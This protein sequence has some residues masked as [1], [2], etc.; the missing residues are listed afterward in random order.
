MRLLEAARVR[1]P[2]VIECTVVTAIVSAAAFAR[3]EVIRRDV[4]QTTSPS[5]AGSIEQVAGGV[6]GSPVWATQGAVVLARTALE[7]CTP[8][9]ATLGNATYGRVGPQCN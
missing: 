7:V 6:V 3:L 5:P 9:T 2:D 8:G 1:C 4:R